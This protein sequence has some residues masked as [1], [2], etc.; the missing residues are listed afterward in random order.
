MAIELRKTGISVVGDVPWGT[1]FCNFYETKEDLLDTLVPYFKVGLENNELCVW[2]ISHPLTEEEVREALRRTVPRFDQYVAEG[3][4]E[5]HM[6]SEWYLKDG[7]FDLQRVTGGWNAKLDQALVRGYDGLRV[8]GNT[9]WLEKRDWDDFREYERQINE[10]IT[11]QRIS[12]LCTYPLAASGAAEILDVARNH[13][14]AVAKRRGHWEIVETPEL[15]QAKAEIVR[16]N[17][18]LEQR[19]TERTVE[20]RVANEELRKEIIERKQAEEKLNTTTKQLRA[21]SASVQSGR[22]VEGTRIAREIHDELGGALTSLKWDLESLDKV[23]SESSDQPQLQVLREK[24]EAML[25]LSETTISAVRRIASELRP[26]VLDDL[27]LAEAIEWQARKFR[28]RTGIICY[29]EWSVGTIELNKEQSTAVFRIFQEA[30]TNILHHAE[31]TRVDITLKEEADEFVLK[32]SDNGRGIAEGD[33]SR[34]QSLGILG[35]QERAYLI[36]GDFDI[37]GVAGQG[38]VVTVRVSNSKR[39]IRTGPSN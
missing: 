31:A 36:G 2:V 26:S 22:E 5:I 38:T 14:F 19:V 27:G 39:V 11:G 24:I 28:A 8:S 35:M 20:L 21:L 34:P 33:K 17:E 7:I 4:L 25:R 1:H 30:L 32:V 37:T 16:L 23:I 3:S 6:S 13:Q 18:E 9:A 10:S 12:L 29:C 15:K